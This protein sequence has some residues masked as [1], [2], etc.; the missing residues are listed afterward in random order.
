[1]PFLHENIQAA[2]AFEQINNLQDSE[3]G[4]YYP[5]IAKFV[6]MV[7]NCGL[8][9]SMAF[10]AV[11]GHHHVLSH[12]TAHV[13][14]HPSLGVAHDCEESDLVEIV[15]NA[16]QKTY[17]LITRFVTI[18]AGWL[19]RFAGARKLKHEHE[20]RDEQEMEQ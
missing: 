15:V 8:A 2:L 19:K 17:R 4:D 10:L 13:C 12:L 1:M 18:A 6:P 5:I 3:I 20:E 16:D 14:S 7:M 9:Q 11:K